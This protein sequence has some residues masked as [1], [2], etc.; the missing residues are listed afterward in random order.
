MI[1]PSS[2]SVKDMLDRQHRIQ[3][4]DNPYRKVRIICIKVIPMYLGVSASV[5]NWSSGDKEFSLILDN[6][7]LMELVEV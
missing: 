2:S 4:E 1:V 3:E 7:P 5:S 6:N